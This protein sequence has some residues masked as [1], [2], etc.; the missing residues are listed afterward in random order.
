MAYGIGLH[1]L[2]S[3]MNIRLALSLPCTLH[4]TEADAQSRGSGLPSDLIQTSQKSWLCEWNQVGHAGGGGGEMHTEDV[5]GH[6]EQHASST[7]QHLDGPKKNSDGQLLAL[8]CKM[9]R[10]RRSYIT[11]AIRLIIFLLIVEE[12]RDNWISPWGWM[13]LFLLDPQNITTP[14]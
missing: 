9:E 14:A 3:Q 10:Y 1:L 13:K 11:I 6:H 5:W 8:W 12:L 7:P 2:I 4:N